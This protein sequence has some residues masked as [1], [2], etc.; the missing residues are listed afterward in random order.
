M[1]DVPV[2]LENLPSTIGGY[3]VQTPDGET[4]ILNS[5]CTREKNMQTYMHE[6]SHIYNDDFSSE[7]SADEIEYSAHNEMEG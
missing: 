1:N 4:I 7:K 2:R 3:V 5:R 6:L